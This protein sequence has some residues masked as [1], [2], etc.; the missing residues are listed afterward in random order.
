MDNMIFDSNVMRVIHVI[1]M[2]SYL[3]DIRLSATLQPHCLCCAGCC[4]QAGCGNDCSCPNAQSCTNGAAKQSCCWTGTK[5]VKTQTDINNCGSCGNVCSAPTG[6]TAVCTAGQCSSMCT[7]GYVQCGAH[8]VPACTCPATCP[9]TTISFVLGSTPPITTSELNTIN[10]NGGS[11]SVVIPSRQTVSAQVQTGS[12]LFNTDCYNFA[13]NPVVGSFFETTP[14]FSVNAVSSTLD[15]NGQSGDGS[16]SVGLNFLDGKATTV[17]K[18]LGCQ[19]LS[20]LSQA[21][22]AGFD[23][24]GPPATPFTTQASFSLACFT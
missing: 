18:L 23:N 3:R 15:V 22:L 21:D 8:C 5:C 4:V 13:C 11:G 17:I 10:L 2:A 14:A 6:A 9:T 16:S 24:F 20:V 12:L 19:T 7:S 1:H